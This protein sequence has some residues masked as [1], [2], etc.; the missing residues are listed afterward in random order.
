MD[1]GSTWHNYEN[2]PVLNNSG[3]QDFRDPKVFWYEKGEK[4]VM[5]LAVGDKIKLFSSPNLKEWKFESDFQP[6]N[7]SRNL[8][9]WECPDLFELS[10]GEEKKWVMIVNHGD[11]TPN[12][13][14]GT[15]YFVGDFDGKTFKNDQQAIWLDY[16]MDFYAGVTFGNVPNEKT[17]LISWMSNWLY[18]QK[19]PTKVWRSAMTL[20]RELTLEKNGEMYF[21]RQEIVKGLSKITTNSIT[22]KKVKLPF[23]VE[24]DDFSQKELFFHCNGGDLDLQ[25]SNSLGEQLL[26]YLK[27]GFLNIDRSGAGVVGFS[28]KFSEKPQQMPLKD[29]IYNFQ[30]IL[31]HASVEILLNDGK[32]SMTSI[33]FPTKK[34]TKIEITGRKSTEIQKLKMNDVKRVWSDSQ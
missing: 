32:Y 33:F 16:G 29:K 14:S 8:G 7:D 2:K 19:T 9:V 10:V 20:A 4:W 24:N 28:E 31:D 27:D 5:T 3:E 18:A 30:I 15:R 26:I 22:K 23:V 25:L 11:Y 34:F 13:G 1:E 6:E 17:I 21:L 12:G